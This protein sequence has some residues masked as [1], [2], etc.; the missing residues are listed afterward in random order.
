MRNIFLYNREN[1]PAG[2]RDFHVDD[3]K[4]LP[5]RYKLLKTRIEERDSKQVDNP[6]YVPVASMESY[7][8][9]VDLTLKRSLS[10]LILPRILIF[11]QLIGVCL[12][13]IKFPG[14]FH[15]HIFSIGS[16]ITLVD[17]HPLM[18]SGFLGLMNYDAQKMRNMMHSGCILT[19]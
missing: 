7:K 19:C 1:W 10:F 4:L 6:D 18:S 16:L 12:L 15:P 11:F 2:M 9:Y 17:I 8:K 13:E 3:L 5:Q 14:W